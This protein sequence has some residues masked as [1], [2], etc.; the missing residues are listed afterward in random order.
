VEDEETLE[1][2]TLVGQLPE[3]IQNEIDDLLA[4]GVMATSVVVS[5]VFFAAD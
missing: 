4:N 1:S 2:G 5:G 3:T